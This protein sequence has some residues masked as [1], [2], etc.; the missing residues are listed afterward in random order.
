[1]A[2]ELMAE[3]L[4]LRDGEF[5]EV[6]DQEDTPVEYP[7]REPGS[8][9]QGGRRAGRESSFV[10]KPGPEKR[11]RKSVFIFALKKDV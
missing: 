11:I 7:V 3:Y 6:R 9:G 5:P 1:M 2:D 4:R 8:T 10:G